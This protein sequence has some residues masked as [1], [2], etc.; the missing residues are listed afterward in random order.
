MKNLFPRIHARHLNP[1]RFLIL[2][3]VLAAF[4]ARALDLVLDGQAG[5]DSNPLELADAFDPDLEF[6]LSADAFARHR[7]DNGIY[8]KGRLLDTRYPGA[9]DADWSWIRFTPGYRSSFDLDE[10]EIRYDLS[11]DYTVFDLVYIDKDTGEPGVFN[12]VSIADRFDSSYIDANARFEYRSEADTRF[13]LG[14][15]FRDKDYENIEAVGLS[16]LDY[17]HDQLYFGAELRPDDKNRVSA[18]YILTDREYVDRRAD[19]LNGDDIPGTDLE[20]EFDTLELSY[21]YRPDDLFRFKISYSVENREDNASGFWDAETDDLKAEF[22]FTV[23]DN[24]TLELRIRW[25]EK[26][27]DQDFDSS[28]VSTEEE[29]RDADRRSIRLRFTERRERQDGN[30]LSY[31]LEVESEKVDSDDPNDEY[32]RLVLGAGIRWHYR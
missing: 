1:V 20:F 15:Q 7:F 18:R 21:R 11:L 2:S 31:Y 4:P 22:R 26:D 8:I 16:D 25:R 23:A 24:Q 9:S 19:D 17:R 13:E 28:L 32:D 30:N 12:G 6:Y 14:V 3:L 27:Y 10:N 29:S 5:F